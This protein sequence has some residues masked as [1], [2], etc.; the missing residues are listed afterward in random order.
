M[1]K[2]EPTT[3]PTDYNLV[4]LLIEYRKGESAVEHFVCLN[5]RELAER[6]EGTDVV[7]HICSLIVNT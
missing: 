2:P 1:Q 4:R 5:C 7:Y 6:R 3:P